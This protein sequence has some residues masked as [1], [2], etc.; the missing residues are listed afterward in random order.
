ML[1]ESIASVYP[2]LSLQLPSNIHHK[3]PLF[4]DLA[5]QIDTKSTL[6]DLALQLSLNSFLDSKVLV[7]LLHL[8]F[9][10]SLDF[11]EFLPQQHS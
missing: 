6:F 8:K 9:L 1:I 10:I 4:L 2:I 5:F 7:D 3:S 11:V